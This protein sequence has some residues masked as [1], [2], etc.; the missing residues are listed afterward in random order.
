MADG[1]PA[2][3]TR[4]LLDVYVRLLENGKAVY[5]FVALKEYANGK[6]QG[7]TEAMKLAMNET[8]LNWQDKS[9]CPGTYGATH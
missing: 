5:T 4:E 7:N 9:I 6:A 8:D 3:G 1:A 2:V